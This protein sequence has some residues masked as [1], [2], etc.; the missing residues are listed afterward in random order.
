[1]A[2]ASHH[3]ATE[4]PPAGPPAAAA[5]EPESL[6]DVDMGKDIASPAFSDPSEDDVGAGSQDEEGGRGG[7]KADKGKGRGRAGRGGRGGSGSGGSTN[8]GGARGGARGGGRKAT[9]KK[10]NRACHSCTKEYANELYPKGSA[11][12]R[13]CK[14]SLNVIY[15]AS[16]AQG[17]LEWY[18]AQTN[19]SKRRKHLVNA[20]MKKYPDPE[21]GK[22]RPSLKLLELVHQVSAESSVDHKAVGE[23]MW[24]GH[25]IAHYQ[26]PKNGGFDVD[27]IKEMFKT[28]YNTPGAIT[29]KKGPNKA[30]LRVWMK[31][32]DLVEYRNSLVKSKM[33]RVH[34]KSVKKSTQEDVDKALSWVQN[35][36]D[37]AGGASNCLSMPEQGALLARAAD[38]NHEA[39]SGEAIN[40]ASAVKDVLSD[41]E[42]DTQK[43]D[44][45]EEDQ[46]DGAEADEDKEEGPAGWETCSQKTKRSSSGIAETTPQKKPKWFDR[47]KSVASA[48]RLATSWHDS[49]LESARQLLMEIQAEEVKLQSDPAMIAD[50]ENETKLLENR[51]KMLEFVM[52]A[53]A[54]GST[55]L[56]QAIGRYA[57]KADDHKAAIKAAG[58]DPRALAAAAR[59]RMGQAPPCKSFQQLKTLCAFKL[60]IDQYHDTDSQDD[61]DK[62]GTKL[63]PARDA[64]NELITYAK[65]AFGHLAELYQAGNKKKLDKAGSKALAQAAALKKG[66]GLPSSTLVEHASHCGV[67]VEVVALAEAPKHFKLDQPLVVRVG[68]QNEMFPQSVCCPELWMH[69]FRSSTSPAMPQSR[70]PRKRK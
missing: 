67:P 59:A 34:E 28:S 32:K 4:E 16:A 43:A 47:D 18:Y 63:Q 36:V 22:K 64:I 19:C 56:D 9:V 41:D 8:R 50:F 62:V 54:P 6:S 24:I 17:E 57:R 51:R 52:T 12:C 48:V 5:A 45:H 68:K 44:E 70:M 20:Y 42:N 58:Q 27:E 55:A 23:M 13:R 38:N 11:N 25:A 29:D 39:F 65:Q 1:M 14:K 10:G 35:N 69:S 15:N 37:K 46:A 66:R 49:Q 40:L 21:E 30:P 31:T 60:D 61:I 3:P 7:S 2:R 26:K 53:G 33:Y